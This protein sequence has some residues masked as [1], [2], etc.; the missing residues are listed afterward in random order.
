MLNALFSDSKKGATMM[1]GDEHKNQYLADLLEIALEL[2]WQPVGVRFLYT[3]E[4]YGHS[5][6]QALKNGISYCSMV[7]MAGMGKSLKATADASACPGGS[8]ATGL[9]RPN[10]YKKSGSSYDKDNMCMYE[11]TGVAH[12]VVRDMRFMDVDVYG[13]DLRPL[14]SFDAE[15]PDVVIVIASPYAA[16]RLVQG[17][18]YHHGMKK[19]VRVCGNQ[20]LCSELTASPYM[21]DDIN[22]SL[23][24]SGTRFRCNWGDSNMGAGLAYA[25]LQP[26]V[27]GLFATMADTETKTKKQAIEERARQKGKTVQ[28]APGREYFARRLKTDW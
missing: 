20:A 8:I 13:L 27:D 18:A 26:V 7:R 10:L 24:C 14:R 3:E 25:K 22:L 4:Q 23:L 21:T 19:D 17:Y 11:T 9:Q 28:T 1:K 12:G 6:A 16:M 15:A 5:P 2:E